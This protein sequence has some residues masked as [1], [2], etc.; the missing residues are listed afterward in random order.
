MN[1]GL[2]EADITTLKGIGMNVLLLVVVTFI[3]IAVAMVVDS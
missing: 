1:I 3:L 2:D